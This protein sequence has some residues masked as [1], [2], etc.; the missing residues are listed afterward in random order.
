MVMA[1]A[2]YGAAINFPTGRR[3]SAFLEITAMR[4]HLSSLLSDSAENSRK[5][6]ASKVPSP[7]PRE[8]QPCLV[9][10]VFQ[11]KEKQLAPTETVAVFRQALVTAEGA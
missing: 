11:M 3:A 7:K 1:P 6:L 2:Y 10:G 4:V 8:P 9:R 5:Q